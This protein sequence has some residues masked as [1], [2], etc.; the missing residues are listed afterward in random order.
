M[1]FH[2]VHRQSIR[3]RRRQ[4]L[5]RGRHSEGAPEALNA[6]KLEAEIR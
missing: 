3:E 2:D 5:D 4:R 1:V 6:G